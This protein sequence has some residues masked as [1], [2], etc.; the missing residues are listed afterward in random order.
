[1]D[2]NSKDSSTVNFPVVGIGA[3]AGGLEA[4]KL[5]LKGVPEKSGM[6]YVYVQHLSPKH[7]SALTEILS[8][9]AKIPVREITDDVRLQPDQFYVIPSTKMLTA[10]DGKLKLDPRNEKTKKI[11]TIDLFFSSLGVV[12]QSFAVGVVLSGTLDDGTLGLQVIKAHGGMTFVQDD[13]AAYEGMPHN[14][15]KSGVADFILPPEKIAEKL[16]EINKPFHKDPKKV[17]EVPQVPLVDEEIF[18]RILIVLRAKKKVDFTYYKQTT[19]IR[20]IQRRMALSNSERPADYLAMLKESTAEQDALY[21]D[22]LISVSEFF[23]DPKTFEVLSNSIIPDL[24]HSKKTNEPIRIWVA[25]CATGEEAYSMAIC[26]EEFL[27][28]NPTDRAPDGKT[29]QIFATDLSETAIAKARTGLYSKE[30]LKMVSPERLE[31]FFNKLDDNYLVNKSIRNYCVFAHHDL[32]KDP[33]F[34]KMDIVSCRNLLIYLE[35]ILQK[36]VFTILHYA[37]KEKGILILGKSETIG[38]SSELFASYNNKEKI[39]TKKGATGRFMYVASAGNEQTMRD[40]DK[41]S[42]PQKPVT[43]VYKKVEEILLQNYMPAGVLVNEA[44]DIVQFRGVTDAWLSPPPGKATF[45]LLKMAR[46]GLSFELR[47]ILNFAKQRNTP[48]KKEGIAMHLNG[49]Q[50]YATIEAIPILDTAQPHF[51]VLFQ[52]NERYATLEDTAG[53][54]ESGT[55]EKMHP[56]KARIE[57]LEKELAQNREDMRS[58]TEDQQA[59]NEEMQSANEE[60]LSGSE[61][62]QAVNEELE[63]GKEELQSTNEELTSLNHELFDRNAQLNKSQNYTEGVFSTIRD[64]II[65]LDHDFKI[66]KATEGFYKKFSLTEKETEGKLLFTLQSGHW[67]IPDLKNYLEGISDK[68]SSFTDFEITHTFPA[69]GQR[70]MI[71][72]GRQLERVDGNKTILVAIEDVTDMKKVEES[73]IHLKRSNDD[74]ENSNLELEQFAGI[75]SHDLQEPLRKVITFINIIESRN[76]AISEEAKPYISK[77]ATSAKRMQSIIKELLNYTKTT[78]FEQEFKP[79]DLNEIFKDVLNDFEMAIEEKGAE[80]NVSQLPV[81][82]AIGLYMNQLFYNLVGNALKFSKKDLPPK[83]EITASTL[84]GKELAGHPALNQQGAFTEIVV[85]DNG[86]GFDEKYAGQIFDLFQRLHNR[87]HY[88]GTGIGLALCRKIVL[89]HSGKIYV[90]SKEGEGTSFHI[91]LPL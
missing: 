55:G 54:E 62:L 73:L 52:N 59:A 24:L 4:I 30:D 81:I 33:P 29:I 67:N 71:V 2:D 25:G 51:L 12:H 63:T 6:A 60:L 11:K 69:I 61:E 68:N 22:M 77:I 74:L 41:K 13:T 45:N 80:I 20:R 57:Q 86:I 48:A 78:D 35:P 88:D 31:H 64:A 90:K 50:Q 87:A 37:L 47:N 18:R 82:P 40:E 16:I 34:A 46:E 75:A 9:E 42:S 91:I 58:I 72:N 76:L 79:T 28:K 70:T 56:L 21:K 27:L 3:S 66:I 65:V 5:F 26:L 39:Y 8:K 43:D 84:N 44:F 83:I 49:K 89:Q 23:R 32:L 17:E 19:V 10:V 85:K 7:E 36:K 15:I 53:Q 14:A 38:N 1:M